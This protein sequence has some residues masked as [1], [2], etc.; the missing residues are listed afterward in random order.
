MVRR[1]PEIILDEASRCIAFIEKL[2]LN[3]GEWTGKLIILAP[4]QR[5]FIRQLFR[6]DP[7][8]KLIT[9]WAFLGIPRKSGKSC[10]I[11]GICLYML[12]GRGKKGIKIAS[13]ACDK[14]QASICF[15]FAADMIR[16]S[17]YLSSLC[18]IR[19]SQRKILV[20]SLNSLY[21]VKS[22][23]ADNKDGYGYDVLV[24]DELHAWKK[25]HLYHVMRS[26]MKAKHEPMTLIITT[27]GQNP[28]CLCHQLW[29]H[30][31]T[32]IKGT[33]VDPTAV[34]VLYEAPEGADAFSEAVWLQ[35]HPGIGH[36]V[37]LENIKAE[38]AEALNMPS[39][40]AEFKRTVCNIWTSEDTKWLP[41]E[42][43]KAC[44]AAPYD[45]DLLLKEKC[46][47]GLD[48]ASTTD[49]SAFS[50][51][52]PLDDGRVALIVRHYMPADTLLHAERRDGIPY[53]DYVDA[54]YITATPGNV[55]DYDYIREDINKAFK[56]YDFTDIAI[57]PY[58]A[59]QLA[60]QLAGDG[61]T[62]VPHRQGFLSMSGPAKAFERLV[63][64]KKLITLKNPVLNHQ[65]HTVIVT[66][67]AADNIKPTKSKETG[68][69]DG[70]VASVMAVGL[71][72]KYVDNQP[73]IFFIGHKG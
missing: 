59:T 17:K 1:N 70:I 47:G 30:A 72:A 42:S 56:K 35:C 40:I 68:R 28:H 36:T 7:E 51:A 12:L 39:Q 58:N 22:G 55:T 14:D 5:E 50:L 64:S 8:G 10:L 32:L 37:P 24:A 38:A 31:R 48:L 69:I 43:W 60:I 66:R 11:A 33:S 62:V 73:Q 61:L 25:E 21:E 6:T 13:V 18:D 15:N 26:G 54:G 23:D 9:R 71:A 29:E 44:A 63:I 49:L 52:F 19:K 3:E 67:D 57:D 46:F 53:R 65:A 34:A 41:Y 45:A 4:W 20:P 16:Q 2:R 27:A